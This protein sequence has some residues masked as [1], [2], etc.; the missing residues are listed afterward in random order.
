MHEIII[1]KN[2]S[3]KG[4]ISHQLLG[5]LEKRVEL[6]I[7]EAVSCF[8]NMSE[9]QLLAP[10]ADGGWSIAQCLDHLNSYGHY[11][12]P[13]IKQAMDAHQQERSGGIFKSSWLGA[14]FTRMMEPRTGKRKM[15][16]MKGHIPA[17]NL[18]AQ[19]VVAEFI[20]QQEVLL[21]YLQQARKVDLNTIRIP[22]SIAKWIRLKLGDVFQ[23]I[24]AHNERHVLQAR[25]NVA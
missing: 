13:Q 24:I 18:D 6:H 11:Y 19:A 10:A 25:R 20:R 9:P 14:Y 7:Q 22:V 21:D 8:Q 12:L 3:M 23:F 1:T 15:K 16:A 17:A 4:V 5:T 2:G